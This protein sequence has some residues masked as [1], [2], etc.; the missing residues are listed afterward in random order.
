MYN[1]YVRAMYVLWRDALWATSR[2]F[3]TG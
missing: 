1:I 2:D 3:R